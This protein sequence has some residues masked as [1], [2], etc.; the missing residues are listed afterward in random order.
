MKA[1]LA[2]VV[3]TERFSAVLMGALAALG[4]TLAIIGLYGAMSYSVSC[5]TREMGLR[6]ALGATPNK[7]LR[8][9]A[10][11]GL[12]L[13]AIG[14]VIGSAGALVVTRSLAGVLYHLSASDPLTFGLVM[15]LLAS[16]ALAAC[17]V[18][19]R[20][21]TQVDPMVALRHE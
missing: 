10:G 17:Y 3:V 18:P 8:M 9:V 12:R 11:R 6:L 21:A 15:A 2:G 19:A 16:V 1:Q 5:E 7:I 14:L 20:R 4:L 13:I